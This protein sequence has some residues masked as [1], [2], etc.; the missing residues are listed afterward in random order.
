MI[1]RLSFYFDFLKK[2]ND[3]PIL[4]IT[5]WGGVKSSDYNYFF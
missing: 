4:I 5:Y 3:M 2:T 1:C